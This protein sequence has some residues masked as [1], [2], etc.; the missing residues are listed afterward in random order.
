MHPSP[1]AVWIT[2]PEVLTFQFGPVSL[3]NLEFKALS[4][5]S[6]PFLVSPDLPPPIEKHGPRTAKR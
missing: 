1:K 5:L 6:N 3:G 4:L 2:R